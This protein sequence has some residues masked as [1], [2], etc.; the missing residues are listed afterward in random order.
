[1]QITPQIWKSTKYFCLNSFS[2]NGLLLERKFGQFGTDVFFLMHFCVF[3]IFLR[4]TLL[5]SYLIF[6]YFFSI[7]ILTYKGT[8]WN[9]FFQVLGIN[10]LIY[11][12]LKIFKKYLF[13]HS[14]SVLFEISQKNGFKKAKKNIY[15][16]KKY[17]LKN[18]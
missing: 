1:M 15:Q 16:K 13:L 3:N 12:I 17:D 2:Y 4:D 6:F 7:S 5:K 10:F 14:F 9:S 18:K 8:F 11:R